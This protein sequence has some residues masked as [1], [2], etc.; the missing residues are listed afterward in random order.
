MFYLSVSSL[1]TEV[2]G[3]ICTVKILCAYVRVLGAQIGK[4]TV[5]VG[6][7]SD[8][9]ETSTTTR[10]SDL[11][12]IR[13]LQ[14]SQATRSSDCQTVRP[15]QTSWTIRP[16]DLQIVRPLQ[17]SQTTRSSDCQTVRPLVMDRFSFSYLISDQITSYLIIGSILS[18]HLILQ[19]P[20]PVPRAVH[21]AT[22]DVSSLALSSTT[23]SCTVHS[24]TDSLVRPSCIVVYIL[25]NP[26]PR[27]SPF[28]LSL[29]LR[30][31]SQVL[32]IPLPL[33]VSHVVICPRFTL[34]HLTTPDQSDHQTIRPPD[35]Q[36]MADQSDH[37]TTRPADYQTTPD[38]QTPRLSH[39]EKP[40]CY[41]EGAI[42]IQ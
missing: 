36:T 40:V 41:I 21:T 27:G 14:T 33:R 30:S 4:L 6:N 24:L 2:K 11:Q 22:L 10:P 9:T 1:N 19:Q 16:S 37:Q 28:K 42:S 31:N 17:T 20:R 25:C 13:P 26:T 15:L 35:C 3:T 23:M 39:Q 12:T 8:R 18:A 38:H 34:G 5:S 32:S 29:G 7:G